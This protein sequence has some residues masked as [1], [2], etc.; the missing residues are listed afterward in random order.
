MKPHKDRHYYE[1]E[2]DLVK[3]AESVEFTIT[4][5]WPYYREAL[6]ERRSLRWCPAH[7]LKDIRITLANERIVRLK[8]ELTMLR[9]LRRDSLERHQYRVGVFLTAVD[10][11]GTRFRLV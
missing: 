3:L 10:A 7:F 4:A 11:N 9:D 8:S 6:A 5:V 1:R 2:Y